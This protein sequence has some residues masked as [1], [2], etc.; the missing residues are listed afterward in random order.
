MSYVYSVILFTVPVIAILTKVDAFEVK[1]R[2]NIF[3]QLQQDG[4]SQPEALKVAAPR[5]TTEA[6]ARIERDY[7]RPLEAVPYRPNDIIQ[8]RGRLFPGRNY[9]YLDVHVFRYEPVDYQLPRAPP[10]HCKESRRKCSK[11]IL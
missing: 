7:I 11:G 1:V 8:L 5:A 6:V 10:G 4:L 3:W 2:G 9:L